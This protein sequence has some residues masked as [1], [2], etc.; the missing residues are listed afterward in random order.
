MKH[1]SE[2]SN[3]LRTQL[4]F[5]KRKLECLAQVMMGMISCRTVNL[6]QLADTLYG[7]AKSPSKYRRL[8]RLFSQWSMTT[9]GLGVWLISWFYDVDEAIT[10]TMDRTNWQWG[11]AKINFLVIGVVYKR[12]AI[13]LMWTLLPK[14]GNSNCQER[15]AIVER[16]LKY[17]KKSRIKNLLCDRE[18]VG[19]AW[20]KWLQKEE[21]PFKIRI[22]H[23]YVTE[24][25][26][27]K[28]TT[29]EALFYNLPLGQK[30]VIRGQRTI[31]GCKV[32]LTG[33]RLQSGDLMVIA[34][35]DQEGCSIELY[36][37]RW[38]IETLFE[39]LK[40]RG[41]DLEC[42]HITHHDRLNALLTVVALAAC[43]AYRVGEWRIDQGHLIKIKKHGRPEKSLFRHGLDQIRRQLIQHSGWKHIKPLV[44]LWRLL[45]PPKLAIT[46]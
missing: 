11:K 46:L 32:F 14:K 31:T 39:N 30:R 9:D 41:F 42:T 43:W 16:V 37:E 26:T 33:S 15:I 36:C 19:G 45:V 23:N 44:D 2:L 10:L 20:F 28:E 1:I 7:E 3:I 4:P 40:S 18:F 38:E 25:S 27:G 8:Q 12:M 24:T 5:N 6:T 13:P 22:K 34:S 21:I 35:H 29:I 17:I